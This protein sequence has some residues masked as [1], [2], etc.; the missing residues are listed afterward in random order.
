MTDTTTEMACSLDSEARNERRAFFRE[1]LL[2]DA[3]QKIR[4]DDGLR[5]FF[6]ND[7]A[8]RS[9]IRTLIDLERQ[10]C[11]FLDFEL[12]EDEERLTLTITGP[13]AAAAVLDQMASVASIRPPGAA[14]VDS[15]P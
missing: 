7:P 3:V 10:C 2:P 14:A 11:G 13:P 15:G 9:E 1:R 5:I 6:R 4:T 12:A 8:M